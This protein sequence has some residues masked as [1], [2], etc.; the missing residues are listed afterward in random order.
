M[1]ELEK[2][3]GRADKAQ[4]Y[5]ERRDLARKG[6][7]QL[8]TDEGYFVK[9]IDPD[10]TKHGVYGSKKYGYFEAVCNHDAVCFRIADDAQSQKIYEK[11]ASLPGLRPHDL[12][13]TNYPSLDD[14]YEPDTA[15]GYDFGR[16]VNGGHWSTC[17][18]G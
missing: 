18:R 17:E 15:P 7:P 11:M 2:M 6:L 1:I 14:M 8:T 12:I 13:I 9:S 16:W 10:G 4:L 5:A 3:A